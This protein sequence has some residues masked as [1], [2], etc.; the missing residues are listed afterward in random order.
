MYSRRNQ[1]LIKG[2]FLRRFKMRRNR[3]FSHPTLLH[4]FGRM[5]QC[6]TQDMQM[7]TYTEHRLGHGYNGDVIQIN[8]FNHGPNTMTLALQR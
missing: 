6:S 5:G 1:E 8:P 7:D 2:M 3:N 4:C